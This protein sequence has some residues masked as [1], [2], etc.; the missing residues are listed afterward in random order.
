[1]TDDDVLEHAHRIATQ[2]K[3]TSDLRYSFTNLHMLDFARA[4][5]AR[6]L[7]ELRKQAE[8]LKQEESQNEV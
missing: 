7:E 1:M 8:Q 3:H 4:I 2:Y 5:E 6:V